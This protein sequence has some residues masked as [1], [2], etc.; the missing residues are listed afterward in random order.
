[1]I[2]N[3]W[4]QS[5]SP[6]NEQAFYWGSAAADAHG[7]RNYMGVKS[8][9]VDAMIAALLKAERRDGF[10]RGRARAR[11]R[12]DLRLL[13]RPAVPSARAMGRA[14]DAG[15]AV[16][17]RPRCSATCPKPGGASR[18][19]RE[20]G[21]VILG[22]PRKTRRRPASAAARRSTICCAARRNG[23]PMRSRC[24][25]RPTA[26]A[27]PTARRAGS[28][29]RR[30]IAWSRPS[31]AGCAAWGCRPTPS[32]ASRLANTVDGVL[33]AARRP[34]RG[35]DRDA[36]AAAVAAGRSGRRARPRRRQRADRERPHRRGRSLRPRHADRGRDLSD[37]LRLRLRRRARPTGW[38]RS[39]ISITADRLDPLPP[40]DAQRAAP[41][42]PGAH[43]AVVTWDVAADGLGAGR[44]QPCRADRRRPCRAARKPHRAGRGHPD[45]RSRCPRSRASRSRCCPGCWSAARWR[46]TTRSI[47]RR[48]IGAAPSDAR[49]GTIVVPGPLIAPFVAS[50]QLAAGDG[51]AQRDRRVAR[52]GTAGAG[53]GLARTRRR[54]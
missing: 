6:G 14:L 23:G 29:M 24:S 12:A 9:A 28:P 47:P 13:R 45:D 43:L 22:D 41:P 32:S 1:M 54:A 18:I 19:H 4:D 51:L 11:P 20:A 33:D 42:G 27:S 49:R 53:A 50:G 40:L 52:A 34:A 2:Q 31:P 25:I 30:P 38:S 39:T 16:R 37:P 10:R 8:P 48:F 36:A 15:S 26:K 3:R 35:T 44:A 7:T 17:R 21:P 5:L 46:C